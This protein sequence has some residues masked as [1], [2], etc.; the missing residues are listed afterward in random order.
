MNENYVFGKFRLALNKGHKCAGDYVILWNNNEQFDDKRF[1]A[2]L[3]KVIAN[4]QEA[5]RFIDL[6]CKLPH[7]ALQDCIITDFTPEKRSEI[8]AHIDRLD[9]DSSQKVLLFSM[10]LRCDIDNLNYKCPH[11]NGAIRH[12]IQVLLL[13][14]YHFNVEEYKA[15]ADIDLQNKNLVDAINCIGFPNN[16]YGY[17][18]DK[19]RAAYG[20][21]KSL[22]GSA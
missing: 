7:L 12:F 1:F 5:K 14:G 20:K 16:S 19:F 17:S 3:L 11:L 8:H 6:F 22:T 21:Y 4:E 2:G 15:L 9:I 13:L 18:T 10:A